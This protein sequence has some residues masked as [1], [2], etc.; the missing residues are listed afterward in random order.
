[1]L[2]IVIVVENFT[3]SFFM[4]RSVV[5][6]YKSQLFLVIHNFYLFISHCYSPDLCTELIHNAL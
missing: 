4:I 1:L 3:I 6:Y 2:L 5:N